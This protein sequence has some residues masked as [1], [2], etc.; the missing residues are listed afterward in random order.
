SAYF[1]I[2]IHNASSLGVKI[3]V[4]SAK[5][6]N[7]STEDCDGFT[8]YDLNKNAIGFHINAKYFHESTW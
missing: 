6:R 5:G 3:A 2:R 7:N 4:D 1:I 8:D